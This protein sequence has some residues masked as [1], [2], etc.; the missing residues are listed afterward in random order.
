MTLAED[1]SKAISGRSKPHSM[2][3]RNHDYHLGTS[4]DAIDIE[5]INDWDDTMYFH[6]DF[7]SHSKTVALDDIECILGFR[8]DEPALYRSTRQL[9][10]MVKDQL[11]AGIP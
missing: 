9:A 3:V 1:I 5:D 7:A 4:Y 6:Y 10:R 8:A 2:L 11:K